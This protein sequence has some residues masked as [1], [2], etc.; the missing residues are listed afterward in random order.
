MKDHKSSQ[1]SIIKGRPIFK[2]HLYISSALFLVIILVTT[3]TLFRLATGSLRDRVGAELATTTEGMA[4]LIREQIQDVNARLDPSNPDNEFQRRAEIQSYL[5]S[6]MSQQEEI[7]YVIIQDLKGEIL[8]KAIRRG[9]ELEQ[10][11]FSRILISPRNS[12]S[13]KIEVTS[14]SSPGL[15]YLDLI[16]PILLHGQPELIVHFGIDNKL[17][18]N[19][20][21][22]LRTSI[23]RRI[24]MGS[25]VVGGILSVALVYVLWLLKRAQMVEAE[26]HMADR[27][28]YLGTLA[29]GLAHEIRNPLS[30]INLNLQMIEEDLTDGPSE[31]SELRT[32]LKG[33]KQEIKRLDR[34]A[35]NFLVYAKPLELEK[36]KFDLWEL[37]DE[38]LML[39]QREFTASGIELVRLDSERPL[40]IQGDRDLLQQAILNLIVNAQEA[41][42]SKAAG[43]RKIQLSAGLQNKQVVI[44]VLDSGSG[45]G[46]EE[47][48]NLFKLFYSGKRGGTGLGLPIAQ[49]IVEAHGGRIEWRN[50]AEGGAEFTIWLNA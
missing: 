10:N 39:V 22:G 24:L 23:I 33:T 12:R 31:N 1:P 36:Q 11:Q 35:T 38:V 28:A 14:L 40:N 50:V 41:V 29:G 26:A 19:R 15:V 3:F 16:E 48:R 47:V 7:L 46:P 32:L 37:L 2:R 30:A 34:L 8:W 9:M 44:R 49:R 21:A 17:L 4:Q 13:P 42:M 20:F 6:V 43:E 45:V 27:L 5:E 25:S 18:E